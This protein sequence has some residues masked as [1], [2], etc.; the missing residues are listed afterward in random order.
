MS[1]S[2]VGLLDGSTTAGVY[3]ALGTPEAMVDEL[4]HAGWQVG[5]VQATT[6]RADFYLEIAGALG[7]GDHFGHNLDA[8]WDC[9]TD[10]TEPTALILGRWTAFAQARPGAWLAILDVLRDRTHAKPPFAVVLA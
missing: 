3:R 2:I 4:Q 1:S 9:L 8:L 5:L 6:S 7:F 10:L